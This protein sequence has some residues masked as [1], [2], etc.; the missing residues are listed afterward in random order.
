MNT[1]VGE[2]DFIIV[3]AGTA[4]C[5]LAN[6]L[7]ENSRNRVLLIE[8]GKRDT[9]PWIHVPAGYLYCIGNPRTDWCFQ[10]APVA[11]LNN[12][13]MGYARGKGLGGCSS[14]NGMIYI[15]GQALDYDGWAQMGNTGWGWDDLLPLFRRHEDHYA[16]EDDMHGVG[17]EVPIRRQ[18]LRWDILDA[19]R[20]ALVENGIP[21]TRDFNRGDNEGVGYFDVTQ[22][23]G[24]RVSAASAFLKP[25]RKR[26]NLRILTQ[27][28]VLRVVFEG[29]CATGVEVRFGGE[30]RIIPA[31]AEVILSSGAIGSPHLLELSGIGQAERLAS[32][33]IA[34]V[35]DRRAVGENLQDH[36]QMRPVFRVRNAKT[37]N[38]LA[39]SLVGKARIG[40]EYALRRTGPLS[41]APSQ[42]GAFVRSGPE[43]ASADLQYHFQPL[44]LEKFGG[45]LDA[46][47]AITASVCNLRPAS[48]GSVHATSADAMAAPA[49]DPNYLSAPEDR[50]KMVSALKLTR[51]LMQ[52]RALQPH[53]PEEVRPGAELTGDEQLVVAAMQHASTIF[54]P[55]STCAMGPAEDAVVDPRLRVR[56]VEAL[57]VIDASVMPRITSGN[58]NAPT[59]V[60][61]EKGAAMII[62]DHRA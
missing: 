14:I 2:F 17:G 38:T 50:Q 5:L 27:A 51:R 10:T 59:M 29:R 18:R 34:V 24:L 11:D 16:G 21:L 43:V 54:H 3:G 6:R 42:L 46:F 58:T 40:I 9:Y 25:A 22:N 60:I 37:L 62:Q 35:A 48:R 7:S 32:L 45:A 39:G 23:K 53:A 56:G 20:A 49:I 15:R 33:G 13:S 19:I 57:R 55:V 26:P 30:H 52:A 8:A 47:P 36:L 1:D 41:M 61:A 4:G 44:S 12:R 28:H 31:R